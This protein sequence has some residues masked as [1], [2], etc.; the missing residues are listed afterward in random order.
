MVIEMTYLLAHDYVPSE[1]DVN[2]ITSVATE[3][4]LKR[5]KWPSLH[6]S[7]PKGAYSSAVAVR[8]RQRLQHEHQLASNGK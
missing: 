5:L 1:Q 3:G 2:E 4:Q 6:S 7:I 8:A